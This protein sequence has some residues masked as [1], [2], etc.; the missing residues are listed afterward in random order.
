M[1]AAAT[2]Q[3]FNAFTCCNSLLLLHALHITS[4]GLNTLHDHVTVYNNII[5]A[6]MSELCSSNTYIPSI[7]SISIDICLFCFV[8][9]CAYI[10]NLRTST[11]HYE[12]PFDIV[13]G[14]IA[15]TRDD[16]TY[17]TISLFQIVLVV[18]LHA[19]M[20]SS[21][22]IYHMHCMTSP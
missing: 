20:I 1:I 8:L 19:R 17:Q 11:W 21:L 7:W 15:L 10:D 9:A 4:T 22:I 14:S 2:L 16:N 5:A 13:T 12:A 6:T 18:S 3:H